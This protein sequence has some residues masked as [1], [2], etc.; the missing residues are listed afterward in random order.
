[1]KNIFTCFFIFMAFA[2]QV[3]ASDPQWQMS[4]FDPVQ[5]MYDYTPFWPAVREAQMPSGYFPGAGSCSA[6][7]TILQCAQYFQ[8][9]ATANASAIASVQSLVAGKEPYIPPSTADKYLRGDKTWVVFPALFS[10]SYLDLTNKPSIPASQVPADWAAT[11]G[12]AQVLNKPYIFDGSWSAITG[13]PSSF[14]PSA[15]A[16]SGADITSGI[17]SD[18]RLPTLAI[19]KITGLQ[20]ALDAKQAS[21][22]TG[23]AGQFYGASGWAVPAYP[24]SSVNGSTGAVVIVSASTTAAGLMSA[25]DKA[26]LDAVQSG[27]TANSS[28]SFLLNRSNHTGTQSVSTIIGLSAAIDGKQATLVSGTSIRTLEGQSLLGA[29]NIDL[30]KSDVGLSNV[31]NTSDAAKPLSTAQL[32]ALAQRPVVYQGS[33]QKTGVK[34]YAGKATTVTGGVAIFY[35]TD[36]GT[37]GG[38]ALLANVYDETVDFEVND[39]VNAYRYSWVISADKKILTATVTRSAP[40]GVIS[41]LGLNLLSAPAATPAGTV[42]RLTA[43]GD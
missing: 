19:S 10:G 28:D 25:S 22:G 29:G 13:V 35:L 4:T 3:R 43:W 14:T 9:A 7:K 38:N 12:P 17:I 11:S 24:V 1:M 5:D 37:S 30:G 36:S 31:D 18:A 16:H 40:T 23:V 33:S 2:F 6:G 8:Y 15:H 26:K 34:I 21:L 39:S 41:L 20:P 27:S 42:V 32:A